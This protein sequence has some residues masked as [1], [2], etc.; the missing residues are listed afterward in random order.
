M[1]VTHITKVSHENPEKFRITYKDADSVLGPNS[2]IPLNDTLEPIYSSSK[3]AIIGAGFSGIATAITC[4]KTLDVDD[5]TIFDKHSN[6]G[7]TWWANTYPGCASD[8]P[9]V[10]YSFFGELNDNWSRLQPPQYEMEEYI[11]KVVDKYGLRKYAK[12]ETTITKAVYNDKEGNWTIY[13][14]DLKTGR[15]VIHTAKLLTSCQG[16]LVNPNHLDSKGLDDFQG[17]YMHSALWD[18][19]VDLKNKKIVVV[20]NGCSANQLIPQLLK[21]YEVKSLF[22][23][24]R[25]KHYVMPPIPE[26]VYTLYKVLSFSRSGLVLSRW[27]IATFAEMRWPLFKGNGLWTRIV[28]WLSSTSSVRYMK[29]APKKFH[30]KL[31]PD[32]KIGCKRLIFDHSY[33][34]SLS[35]PRMDLTN[36]SIDHV[37]K[38]SVVLTDGTEVEADVIIACT[39]YNVS[40]SYYGYQ[41]V[42]RNNVNLVDVWKKEG[43]TAYKTIL[44]RDCPNLFFIAGPNSATG[45]S[46][47]VLASENA[48]KYF[49]LLAPKVLSGA[50]KSIC[51]KTNKYYDWFKESQ[52]EL[53]KCVYGSE[54]GGCVS[55]YT[56]NGV[57]STA[58]PYTQIQYWWTMRHPK[59]EDLE[60][61]PFDYETAGKATKQA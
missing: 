27:I 49:S 59:W 48:A 39:G 13:A 58:Y 18:H 21:H 10:W 54:F 16:G 25:S 7:G 50:Y 42:G 29:K 52:T 23:V 55:W 24:S 45:H 11:L 61:E 22:Q 15:Q 14:R 53:K 57:N 40:E 56:E 3:V 9:A 4:L 35:D 30:D 38:H 19:S 1:S 12:F 28:R 5:I 20:G 32:F 44:A 47:V 41:V 26:F 51:V 17:T 31:I 46:S 8:I 60:L 2:Y 37:T 34:P 36:E 43:P 33:I 6:F